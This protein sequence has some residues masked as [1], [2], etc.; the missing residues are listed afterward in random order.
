MELNDA[1]QTA[2]DSS[3]E[4]RLAEVRERLERA[5]QFARQA[6]AAYVRG[7]FEKAVELLE[8]AHENERTTSRVSRARVWSAPLHTAEKER[9]DRSTKTRP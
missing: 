2:L 5:A 7:K 9:R 3:I 8:Q 4:D 1:I 6:Q